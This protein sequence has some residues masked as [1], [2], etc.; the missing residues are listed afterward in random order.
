MKLRQRSPLIYKLARAAACLSPKLVQ[1]NS[2]LA[3]KRLGKLVQIFH[4]NGHIKAN[5][6]DLA[7]QQFSKCLA[8]IDFLTFDLKRDRLDDFYGKNIG[9]KAEYKDLFSVVKIVLTLSH[10]NAFVE[11]GHSV[12]EDMLV[13]NQQ[14]E[15]LIFQKHMKVH[16]IWKLPPKM[17][18]YA[19][20]SRV[21]YEKSLQEKREQASAEEK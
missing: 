10:G 20:S 7:K 11:S 18:S 13:E 9:Q 14:E 6:T 4:E 12:N 16:L 1:R 2:L 21:S 3:E 8:E 5:S 17:R 15:S 19:R